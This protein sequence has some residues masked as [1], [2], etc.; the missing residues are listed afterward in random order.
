MFLNSF[1]PINELKLG[2]FLSLFLFIFFALG[3]LLAEA[4]HCFYFWLVLG[5]A[6]L[7]LAYIFYRINKL[8]V[9]DI[10]IV[11][12]FFFLG[13]LWQI[14]HKPAS[15]DPFCGRKTRLKVRIISLPRENS[16]FRSLKGL[17]LEADSRDLNQKVTVFDYSRSLEYLKTYALDSKVT[18]RW[19]RQREFYVVAVAKGST[20]S[21]QKASLF[22]KIIRNT[23]LGTLKVFKKN[24]SQQAYQF[25][26][27]V[28]LGRSELLHLQR[29]DFARAGISHLLAISGLHVGLV[30]LFVFFVLRLFNVKFESCLIVS[31][32]FLWFYTFLS[33]AAIPAQRAA[34][35]YSVFAITFLIRR[36]Q[37]VFNGLSLAGLVTLVVWPQ[38]LF[39]I[40]FQ[41]SF[42]AVFSILIGFR[43][44][45]IVLGS[46]KFINY[47]KQL[48]F[49][50]LFVNLG[51][52]GLVSFYFGKIYILTVLY[53]IIFIPFFTFILAINFIMIILS[54]WAVF[55]QPI[56]YILSFFIAVFIRLVSFLGSLEFSS[57]DYRFS[58]LEAG[59]YYLFLAGFLIAFTCWKGRICRNI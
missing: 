1:N 35:M 2:K 33:G 25:L 30:S 57:I 36:K 11:F 49:C 16:R 45:K 56:G 8:L 37:N 53:N 23:V 18:K 28:F 59:L 22:G 3:I 26:A 51:L 44:F 40:S 46:N 24:C 17:L 43:V 13:G 48:F 31:L 34:I 55:A 21:E 9:S 7:V 50:S 10:A 14:S 41:L 19:F 54:F 39:S 38:S 52:L 32:V 4:L 29:E 6:A 42:S 12:F 20:A 5:F 27:A 58:L 15:L 47:I